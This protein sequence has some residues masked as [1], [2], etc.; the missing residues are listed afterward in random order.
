LYGP[1]TSFTERSDDIECGAAG[2]QTV[3]RF[4]NSNFTSLNF[5]LLPGAPREGGAHIARAAT[6]F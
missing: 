1:K 2:K 3:Q 6:P 4:A 5:Q